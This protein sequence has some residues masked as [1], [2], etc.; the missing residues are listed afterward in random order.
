MY[1]HREN[2]KCTYDTLQRG[3][4]DNFNKLAVDVPRESR[5]VDPIKC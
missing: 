3:G 4:Y 1:F 2:L 5:G